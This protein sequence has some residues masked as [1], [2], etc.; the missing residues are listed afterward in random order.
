MRF[1]SLEC[2]KNAL[3]RTLNRTLLSPHLNVFLNTLLNSTLKPPA[4][5][6]YTSYLSYTSYT[7]YSSYNKKR[8][9]LTPLFVL[10]GVCLFGVVVVVQQ[11]VRSFTEWLA[12]ILIVSFLNLRILMRHTNC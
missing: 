7:S 4:Y 3:N 5:S 8:S 11:L 1:K 12:K 2:P 10:F 9:Q 6:S